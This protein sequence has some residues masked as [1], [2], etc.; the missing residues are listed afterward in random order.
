MMGSARMGGVRL[1]LRKH[2]LDV[3]VCVRAFK[4]TQESTVPFEL[5]RH[6]C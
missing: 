6:V 2:E 5:T 4:F 3:I 1:F